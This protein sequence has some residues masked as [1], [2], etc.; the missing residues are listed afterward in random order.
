MLKHKER[1]LWIE[2]TEHSICTYNKRCSLC[3]SLSLVHYCI[4]VGED[5][6]RTPS[7]KD[8]DYICGSCGTPLSTLHKD[9]SGESEVFSLTVVCGIDIGVPQLPQT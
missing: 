2:N 3:F 8:F 5:D 7:P 4:C 6:K 1:K 9:N